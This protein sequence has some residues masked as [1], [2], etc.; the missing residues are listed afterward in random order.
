M[1]QDI[2]SEFPSDIL[3]SCYAPLGPV[4]HCGHLRAHQA[5]DVFKLWDM[6]EQECG[7][8]CPIP[9]W[10]VVWPGAKLLAMYMMQHP[11]VV[12]DKV[13]FDFGAGSGF[14]AAAALSV[15]ARQAIVN[16]I[17]PVALY[18]AK[19][20]AQANDVLP[21]YDSRNYLELSADWGHIDLV[22]ISD[23][24]YQRSQ[25]PLLYEFCKQAHE[26]GIQILI[27]D[28]ERTFAPQASGACVAQR[29]ISVNKALE[30]VGSRSVRLFFF[31]DIADKCKQS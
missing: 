29:T 31:S 1:S 4:E 24:F 17:D 27:A 26:K 11:E 13:V 10:A 22:L 23:M 7:K 25:A 20:N 12:K 6:W 2:L 9:F 5:S 3:L 19:K 16:D 8:Q 28:G 30:G 18:I 21:L 14:A 15:G